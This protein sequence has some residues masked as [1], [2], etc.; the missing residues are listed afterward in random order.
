MIT[1]SQILPDDPLQIEA[2]HIRLED[3][4]HQMSRIN[5]W[6]GA[7][8]AAF[9]VA[10][11]SLHCQRLARVM[12]P[13]LNARIE[14]LML[15]HDCHEAYLGDVIT[16]IKRQLGPI[17]G[18]WARHIDRQVYSAL[19]VRE[20]DETE[21]EWV[22]KIDAQAARIECWCLFQP[23]QALDLCGE[24]PAVPPIW[25]YSD[26]GKAE[27]MAAVVDA[28]DMA[29]IIEGAQRAQPRNVGATCCG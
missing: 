3:M 28:A 2:R 16:P 4:G 5:R 13:E 14:L 10:E 24:V 26:H 21:R 23:A 11:H 18:V 12:A 25:F 9:S 20:P 17:Y 29:R 1:Y 6:N 22:S 8:G 15:L 27:W 19:G 7:S